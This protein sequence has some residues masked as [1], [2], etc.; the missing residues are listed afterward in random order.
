LKKTKKDSRIYQILT[1][2]KEK[3]IIY[4]QEKYKK[5]NK[6]EEIKKEIVKEN[7]KSK[8]NFSDFKIDIYKVRE[9]WL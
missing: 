7:Y 1:S 5:E 8:T 3:I 2:I 9:S 4:S 6:I